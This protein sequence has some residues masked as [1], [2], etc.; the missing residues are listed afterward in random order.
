MSDMELE[1]VAR[2]FVNTWVSRFG[3]PQRLTCDRGGQF[4]SGLFEALS[5]LLG[6]YLT[7]TAS[8]IPQ[9]NGMVERLY[10]PLKQAVTCHQAD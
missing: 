4:E 7:R 3:T 6:V 10:R 9:C 2:T 8:Y 1:T 5:K